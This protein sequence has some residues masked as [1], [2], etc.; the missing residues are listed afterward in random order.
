MKNG[1]RGIVFTA[2]NNQAP[3]LLTSIPII[4]KLG[5]NL[6]IEVMYLGDSDLRAEL[7][8]KLEALP[9][10]VTRILKLIVHDKGWDLEGWDSKPFAILLSSFRETILIDADALFIRNPAILFD[11]PGYLDSG[12]LFFL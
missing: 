11:D 7:R 2:G 6:P 4:R 3:Y 9:R 1:G 5:C 10:V 12:A 8:R